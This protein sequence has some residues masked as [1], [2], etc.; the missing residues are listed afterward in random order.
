MVGIFIYL[1]ILVLGFILVLLRDRTSLLRGSSF[2][3]FNIIFSVFVVLISVFLKQL[4]ENI[5]TFYF[6][7][8]ILFISVLL[9]NKWIFLKYNTNITPLIIEDCAKKILMPFQKLANGYSIKTS[10]GKELLLDTVN[11]SKTYVILNFK[12]DINHNKVAVLQ[13]FMVKK[14]SGI[15]PPIVIRL[16]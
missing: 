4:N 3:K 15:F 9:K 16:K 5:P 11:L 1:L 13:N 10:E 14:F 12:G 8:I 7:L 2:L 6:L